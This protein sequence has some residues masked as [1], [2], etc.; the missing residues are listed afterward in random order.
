MVVGSLV[1]AIGAYV[2]QVLGGRLLGPDGFAPIGTMWTAFFIIATV[3][4]VPVEQYVTREA[5]LGRRVLGS[6]ARRPLVR[7]A[8]IATAVSVV[9][10]LVSAESLFA[11]NRLYAL[12]LGILTVGYAAMVVG[13]GVL[14]GHRRFSGVGWILIGEGAV[15][16]AAAGFFVLVLA[17]SA[18]AL[19]WGMVCAPLAV[20]A[21][22]F[23]RIDAATTEP[24]RPEQARSF[25]GAYVA[26]SSA[27]Q[28]LLAAA[29]LAVA[30]AGGSPALVS[31][32]FVTWTL[33]RGPLT[34]IYSL[35]GRL[36]PYLVR[37]GGDDTRRVAAIVVLVGGALVAIGGLVGWGVGPDVVGLL[38]GAEFRPG[39]VTSG[40]VAAGVVAASAAQV[41]G[42]VLV[43]TGA[44]GR[45]ARAWMSGLAVAAVVVVA[46]PL[47]D[48]DVRVAAGFAAGEVAAL[49]IVAV[50]TLRRPQGEPE[51][52]LAAE[53]GRQS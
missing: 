10:V 28:V 21:T 20:V 7:M 14:A 8:A 27:S 25:L 9:F 45:L 11:G 19:A 46:V 15:R 47:L 40:L 3:L 30:A 39:A 44:T 23:W 6:L 12:Q 42:Q 24:G 5:S 35:Q 18:T 37:A 52:V 17:P 49:L 43:A 41:A 2:F 13:K 22:R 1:G 48:P 33:F 29:P 31:I 34:L 32:A 53:G 50:E 51:A 38:Y 36:L 16:L 26:G 4:L